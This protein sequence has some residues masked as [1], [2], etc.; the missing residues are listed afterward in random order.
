[1]A[2]SRFS[3]EPFSDSTVRVLARE[4][5]FTGSD[6]DAREWL[7]Q[8]V[9]RPNDEFVRVTKDALARSWM[10]EYQG[11]K[12]IVEHLLESNVGPG[13]APRSQ[14]GYANY[15]AK[16]R[17]ASTVRWKLLDALLRFGDR[18][19]G[20]DDGIID[21]VRVPR[22]ATLRV[23][24]Q[25]EDARN[26]HI[27]QQHAWEALSSALATSEATGV[28]EGM[29]VMP[30]GSGKTFTAVRWL[31]QKVL[32]RGHRVLWLAH[33][34]ELLEQT[35]TEFYRAARHIGGVEKLR[36]R[37]V[38]S[39]HCAASTIDPSDHV[40]LAMVG[41]MAR[42][43]EFIDPLLRDPKTFV[44][45]DEA[46][47]AAARTYRNLLEVQR[48]A[49]RRALLGLTAT[50]TRTLEDERGTLS[51]L[52]GGRIFY[53][54]EMRELIERGLLSRPRPV[55]VSTQVSAEE[56]VTPEDLDH[57]QRFDDLSEDWLKRIANYE[58]RNRVIV[59]HFLA[60][61]AKYGKTVVFAIN[62]A[63]AALLAGRFREAGVRADYVASYRPD[64]DRDDS[65]VARDNKA[66]TQRFRAGELDV[67]VNVQLLTEGVDIPEIQTVFL[68]RPT[69]SEILMRQMV[70]RALRGPAAGGTADA[71]LVSFEDH[72]ERFLE[73]QHPLDLVADIVEPQEV[74]D[75]SG[76]GHRLLEM[77]PWDLIKSTADAIRARGIDYAADAFEAIP[78]GWYVLERMVEDEETRHIVP[79]Y[80]HQQPCWDAML[81]AMQ[82][83]S[84]TTRSQLDVAYVTKEFFADCDLPL[85]SELDV[86]RMLDF[87]RDGTRPEYHRLD[88]RK[89]CDPHELAKQVHE[90]D[91]RAREIDQLLQNRYTELAKAIYPTLRDF[92]QAMDDALHELQHPGDAT[93]VPKAVPI[94]RPGPTDQMRPPP[95]GTH[96]H[97]LDALM[98]EVLAQGRE[99]LGMA[100]PLPF[101]ARI[102]WTVR[103]V[104]GW[105]AMAY[106]QPGDVNGGGKI[107]VNRLLDS[108]D[109]SAE[110]LRYL[111]WHEYLHLFLQQGHTKSFKQHETAWPAYVSGARELDTLNERFGIQYW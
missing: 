103:L 61:R 63:H 32:P 7:S 6:G 18:D 45:V 20:S 108:P 33:R 89:D 68:T 69:H 8:K 10:L 30:T 101:S 27:H 51:A 53:Q 111:L 41:S 34:H 109:V 80:E 4:I 71:Y 3:W 62:V 110:T 42:G 47:H 31:A 70:G 86:G 102:E 21:G 81:D 39:K 79:V 92:K 87:V 22:F 93:T 84:P 94:F 82:L 66:I 14:A 49:R 26:P 9:K 25:P 17:N 43:R 95:E 13:G 36:V 78:H 29:L 85:P 57:L 52:F 58:Q 12:Q 100:E 46:H 19:R 15:I 54:V 64:D 65:E 5:G 97:D 90:R 1:V 107:R 77:L 28:F 44:V 98:H 40:V 88:Q 73:W 105:Y 67:L 106:Q 91:L 37:I 83:A 60:N 59:D 38:S 55:P 76:V 104:K 72:W 23:L 99:V 56:G 74:P 48:Q 96:A 50:P 24:E 75:R 11:A 16:C 2:R 35:A